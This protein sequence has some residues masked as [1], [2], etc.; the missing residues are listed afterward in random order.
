MSAGGF[1]YTGPFANSGPV[2]PKVGQETTYTILW[3]LK[4]NSNDLSNVKVAAYI[5]TYVRWLNAVSESNK[6]EIEFNENN[7]MIIWNVGDLTAGT[8]AVSPAKEIAFQV[9]FIPN[10]NQ[11]GSAPVLVES[12]KVEAYDNFV[13]D[14]LKTASPSV[15]INLTQDEKFEYKQGKVV[16]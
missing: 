15:N 7:N 14:S 4:G 8:G 10:P 11:V 5:P 9:S 13:G 1:Y 6:E 3:S 2:P 12:A 16:Q